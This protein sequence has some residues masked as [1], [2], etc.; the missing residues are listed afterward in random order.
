MGMDIKCSPAVS[1]AIDNLVATLLNE[2]QPL[3]DAPWKSLYLF[4]LMQGRNITN[5][6]LSSYS[7]V[8]TYCRV[9]LFVLSHLLHSGIMSR[10]RVI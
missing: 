5:T 3:F 9:H 7:L 2:L 4:P 8:G 10:C 1:T 6:C